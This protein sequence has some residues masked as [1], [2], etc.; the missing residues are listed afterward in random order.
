[1][2][3][4]SF[5]RFIYLD[6]N[7]YCYLAK[8]NHL[9]GRLFDFLIANDLC[10]S[11]S[12]AN[13]SELADTTALHKKLVDLLLL[14]PSAVIKTSDIILNEE[15]KAHPQRRTDSLLLYPLNQLLLK[16]N[17]FETLFAWF[18][19]DKLSK[20]RKEQRMYARQMHDRHLIL[21]RNFPPLKS[22]EYTWR[23][24]ADFA[25]FNVMQRNMSITLRHLSSAFSVL[26]PHSMSPIS[27][28]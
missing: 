28:C 19:S 22:G 16:H 15:V 20:V 24:A 2:N 4:I 9:W 7:I 26:S 14:M 11:L 12:S 10:L 25:S 5:S 1:M 6:T 3:N 18:T 23:Q 27:A 21:K 13:L 17:G 8:N